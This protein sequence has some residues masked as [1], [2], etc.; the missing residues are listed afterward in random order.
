M[1]VKVTTVSFLEDEIW[2]GSI[3]SECYDNARIEWFD[4]DDAA[5]AAALI[6]RHGLTFASTGAGWAANPDG[7]VIRDYATGER[8]EVSAHLFGPAAFHRAVQDLVG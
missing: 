7:S 2:E 6:Q 5:E 3:P 4:V 8:E 1:Q